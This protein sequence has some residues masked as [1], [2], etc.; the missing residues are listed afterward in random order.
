MSLFESLFKALTR[1]ASSSLPDMLRTLAAAEKASS[2]AIEEMGDGDRIV[3][4]DIDPKLLRLRADANASIREQVPA[5]LKLAAALDEY[6]SGHDLFWAK[7]RSMHADEV[8]GRDIM[9]R[10]DKN[11]RVVICVHEDSDNS[12]SECF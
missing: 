1:N 4:A 11:G 7:I 3:V 9:L 5:M 12:D 6:K 10:K 8:S 2:S